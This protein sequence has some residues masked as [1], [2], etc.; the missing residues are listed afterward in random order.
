MNLREA[1]ELTGG[2]LG[3]PSKMPGTSY[4]I[5]AHACITGSKLRKIEGTPCSTC[6][7]FERGNYQYKSVET[8]HERRLASIT[9]PGWSGAMAVLINHAARKSGVYYHRFHDSGDLQSVEHLTKICAVAALA[10][11]V[12][13]WLPTQELGFVNEYVARGGEIPPNLMVRVSDTL[14]DSKHG[15][16][17]GFTSGVRTG[18]MPAHGQVCPAPAQDNK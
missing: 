15:R 10:P 1:K 13:F 5:S 12:K 17:W 2:G 7:C 8:A 3:H 11:K 18:K 4:G 14:N 16:N 9:N 6:Y